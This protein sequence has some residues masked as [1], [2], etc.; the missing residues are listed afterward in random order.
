MESR[1]AQQS[2]VSGHR[3]AVIRP[4]SVF[5]AGPANAL[6]KID[7]HKGTSWDETMVDGFTFCDGSRIVTSNEHASREGIANVRSL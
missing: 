4:R 1:L 6:L 3:L 7:W 5:T 2:P